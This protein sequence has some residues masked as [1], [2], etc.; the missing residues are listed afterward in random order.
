MVRFFIKCNNKGNGGNVADE[1]NANVLEINSSKPEKK[2]FIFIYDAAFV[3][4]F[5]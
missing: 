4:I 3:V 2:G 1:N 5:H